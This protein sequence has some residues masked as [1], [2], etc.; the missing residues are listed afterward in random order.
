MKTLQLSF[1][2]V[3][4][5]F[6][7]SGHSQDCEKEISTSPVAPYNNHAFPLGRYNPWI[8]SAFNIGELENGNVPPMPLNNQ[9]AWQMSDFVFGSA[10]EMWNPYTSAGTSG[11][12]YSYL[13]STG[14]DF[15]NLDYKWEDG[16]EVLHIGLGFY[17]N[18]EEIQVAS[19]QRAYS[20]GVNQPSNPRIPYIILY[21]RYRGTLRVFMNLFT[22]FGGYSDILIW[23][24]FEDEN[25]SGLSGILRHLESFDRPLNQTTNVKRHE[26]FNPNS[27]GSSRW[28]SADFQI[29]Y[30]PC[31]CGKNQ[32]WKISLMGIESFDVNLY[33]R[34]VNLELPI[35]D[36]NGNPN[37]DLD[38]LSSNGIEDGLSGG[39]QIFTKM[40]GL[41]NDYKGALDKYEQDS[42]E[43]ADY[44]EKKATMDAFKSFIVDGVSGLIP[45]GGALKS[46]FLKPKDGDPGNIK[47]A[48]K[49][50]LGSGYDQLSM[51]INPKTSAPKAPDM[52]MASYSEMRFEGTIE[53]TSQTETIGPFFIPGSYD[54]SSTLS[55][56]DPFNYPVYNAPTG[57]AALVET[58]SPLFAFSSTT[59][60]YNSLTVGDGWDLE[61][62]G[63][64]I[65]KHIEN[66]TELNMR[67]DEQPQIHLNPSL[68]FDM[69]KTA[70]YFMVEVVLKN[71]L[72]STLEQ[73]YYLGGYTPL[74]GHVFYQ[75]HD[76]Q[77][78]TDNGRFYNFKSPWIM[79]EDLNQQVFQLKVRRSCETQTRQYLS[80]NPLPPFIVEEPNWIL[81]DLNFE[82]E[83]IRLKIL[84][85]NYFDQIG[86]NGEQVNTTQV[87]SYQLYN[88]NEEVNFL[89][90]DGPW[91]T[92]ASGYFGQ[93][94]PGLIELGNENI[95]LSHPYIH[96]ISGTEIFINAQKV[97]INGPLQ[98]QP[99]YILA[100]QALEEVQVE[101]GASLNPNVHLSIKKDF[102]NTPEF[103]YSDNTTVQNFCDNNTY[104][105]N[106]PS[107]ALRTRI[108][109]E[110][111]DE[112]AVEYLKIKELPTQN[113]KLFPNPANS[114]IWISS[115]SAPISEIQ[116]I[117]IAGRILIHEKPGDSDLNRVLVNIN[118]LQTGIYIVQTQCGNERSSQKLVVGK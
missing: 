20:T 23:L 115:S 27:G 38:W 69:T 70:S 41:V 66:I 26:S 25:P 73:T 16:W 21:N 108:E 92:D 61:G 1:I 67:F 82:I 65:I 104:Q 47:G 81:E 86:S 75:D 28:L 32:K 33:G 52:P 36:G 50:L 31:I 72:P 53:G 74:D 118:S 110:I 84:H 91:T 111:E 105:A 40:E 46:W 3:L 78:E 99:G 95:T 77:S 2:F 35:S 10:F 5:L 54:E 113:I 19:T 24:E 57:I 42:E 101:P 93:Y 88:A 106:I 62:P 37:Y 56:L 51:G 85:D 94:I 7:F 6:P 76:W 63:E 45:A 43:Y 112:S 49:G 17:P 103:Q 100:I 15:E 18:G 90:D 97:H 22:S 59:S 80:Q 98:I 12:R 117:D 109:S 102:Y 71:N 114:Q 29:G 9:I 8:N 116:I 107:S 96:H 14:I 39:N 48:S 83:E 68:D 55:N 44:M 64:T 58:P 4:L 11:R 60:V 79:L 13:H 34:G 89:N 30:D 87:F